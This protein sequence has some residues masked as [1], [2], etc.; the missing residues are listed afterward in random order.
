MSDLERWIWS[1][2]ILKTYPGKGWFNAGDLFQSDS[3]AQVI[4]KFYLYSDYKLYKKSF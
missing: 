1:D 3:E 2:V 4:L